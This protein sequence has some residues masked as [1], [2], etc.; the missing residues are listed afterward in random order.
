MQE[1]RYWGSGGYSDAVF[2]S[3]LIPEWEREI[4]AHLATLNKLLGKRD[5]QILLNEQSAWQQA[6][7]RAADRRSRMP[8][9]EGTMYMVSAA[10]IAMDFPERRALELGC[11]VEILS[12][13]K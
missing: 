10:I 11:R 4:D 9:P 6:R 13:P 1:E 2:F 3:E 5:R 8:R 12:P 7:L